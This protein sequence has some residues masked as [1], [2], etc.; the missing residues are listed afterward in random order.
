MS[1]DP[2]TS[3]ARESRLFSLAVLALLMTCG[4]VLRLWQAGESLWLDELHTSWCVRDGLDQVAPRAA[5]G[6]QSPLYFYLIWAVT[7][8]GGASEWTLRSLSLVAGCILPL[9][10]YRLVKRW[11]AHPP[12]MSAEV[13]ALLAAGLIALDLPSIFFA[14]EARPYALLQLAA[15]RHMDLF[16]RLL[17]QPTPRLRLLFILLGSCL[18][19]LHYTAALLLAA[20]FTAY[21]ILLITN[22]RCLA[23]PA[24]RVLLDFAGMG[25]LCSLALP[26]LAAI[27]AHRQNWEEV[28][29]RPSAWQFFTLFFWTPAAFVVGGLLLWRRFFQPAA[30]RFESPGQQAWPLYATVSLC[31]L[32][33]PLSAAWLLSTTDVARL[34]HHRYLIGA[35]AAVILLATLAV[36]KISWPRI[37]I[38]AA[39][40]LAALGV[41][42]SGAIRQLAKNG[43][44][45]AE[46]GEDWRGAVEF[47][48]SP[49]A[50]LQRVPVLI[51]AGLIEADELRTSDDARLRDY[52]LFPVLGLY[53]LQRTPADLIPLPWTAPWRLNAATLR[54]V[55]TVGGGWFLLRLSEK[56]A[57]KFQARL[58]DSLREQQLSAQ[59]VETHSFP[60]LRL[61]RIE[62]SP[63]P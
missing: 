19:F 9:A 51:H 55:Q 21:C 35:S 11:L 14:Q 34:F 61:L 7:H 52:C 1:P 54:R 43:A 25:L 49:A 53:P 40:G 63:T 37:Q 47:L 32:L 16:C 39:I 24:R 56:K 62:V 29:G 22:R 46:R 50:N 48:N 23:H 44:V 10:V 38:V 8:L 42:Q 57:G 59:V 31:W 3:E 28:I 13:P 41:W 12:D 18:F 45:H 27:F 6:N 17:V 33:V 60:G 26:H 4:V 5:I 30:E 20:E 15:V 2:T 36:D 58:L